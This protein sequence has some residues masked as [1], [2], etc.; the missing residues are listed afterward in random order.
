MALDPSLSLVAW[1]QRPLSC[2]KLAE[3]EVWT[4]LSRMYEENHWAVSLKDGRFCTLHGDSVIAGNVAAPWVQRFGQKWLVFSPHSSSH[5]P[6][7]IYNL[8]VNGGNGYSTLED[9]GIVVLDAGFEAQ[10]TG[11]SY[12]HTKLFQSGKYIHVSKHISFNQATSFQDADL[13]LRREDEFFRLLPQGARGLFS[14]YV[15]S[16]ESDT[17]FQY[18]T[19]FEHGYTLSELLFQQRMTVSSAL[20][21]LDNM[22]KCLVMEVYG[23]PHRLGRWSCQEPDVLSRAIR[24]LGIIRRSDDPIAATLS[25]MISEEEVWINGK[26]FDG[27]PRLRKWLLNNEAIKVVLHPTAPEMCHGDLILDD[28]IATEGGRVLRLVDPNGDATSRLYDVGKTYL[29]T[30][31]FYE[32][33]KYDLFEC[34]SEG[35]H[36][37]LSILNNPAIQL[38]E[39]IGY[40]LPAFLRRAELWTEQ[41]PEPE[42]GLILMLNGLYNIALPMFHLIHHRRPDRA[43]AFFT[44]GIIRLNQARAAL[45]SGFVCTVEDV[46]ESNTLRGLLY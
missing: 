19:K 3:S 14:E 9:H 37:Q 28:V 10:L 35:N 12:C 6:D 24:R 39:Q 5:L 1:P 32:A 45:N 13:K 31:S 29:S 36:I 25:N 11:G 16:S 21:R 27:W 17:H 43:L 18:V 7:V 42:G 4:H 40:E 15:N 33:F 23:T 41:C 22:Y 44:L 8:D 34:K 26:T 30:L 38:I 46:I 2:L 20:A